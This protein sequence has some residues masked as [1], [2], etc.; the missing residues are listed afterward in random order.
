MINFKP[1]DYNNLILINTITI[2]KINKDSYPKVS[3]IETDCLVDASKPAIQRQK[4][5]RFGQHLEKLHP[6]GTLV[7]KS[8]SVP[9][10]TLKTKLKMI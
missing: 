8:I 2:K 7:I 6:I 10:N 1:N 9:I 4:A 3:F 5:V